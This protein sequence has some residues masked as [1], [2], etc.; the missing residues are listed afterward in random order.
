[1]VADYACLQL[2]LDKEP[3]AAKERVIYAV[4]SYMDTLGLIPCGRES[5]ERTVCFVRTA[6]GYAVFDDCADRLDLNALDGLGRTLTQKLHTRAVGVM[7]SGGGLMLRLY[8]EGW[9][10]DVYI[11][12]RQAFRRGQGMPGHLSYRSHAM[13]WR[14]QLDKAYTTKELADAFI[15]GQAGGR[16]VF[17]EL[18]G[19]LRL[20]KTA[21]F[22]FKSIE[23]AGLQGV[24]T[25]YFCPSN[26]VKQRLVDR[27]FH[28]VRHAVT[29]IGA[30]FHRPAGGRRTPM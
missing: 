2:A 12:S 19:M 28:P 24:I 23:D 10:R 18:R 20:D 13:R 30:F 7:A 21:D 11:T 5:T 6:T 9:L 17:S 1:M 14:S 16:A 8:S 22:G 15:R 26:V 3:E 25:L 29:S 4:T 27:L